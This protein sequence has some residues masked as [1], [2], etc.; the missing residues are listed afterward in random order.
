MS[1]PCLSILSTRYD[2]L[3]IYGSLQQFVSYDFYENMLR[4]AIEK[5]YVDID[6][7]RENWESTMFQF[8]V[9]D[10]YEIFPKLQNIYYANEKVDGNCK[11]SYK[12]LDVF[13]S[14]HQTFNVSIYYDCELSARREKFVDFSVGLTL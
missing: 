2:M 12:K 7:T 14:T 6:L 10:L 11:A 9:G 5:G 8:F 3:R 1:L 13:K 4:F